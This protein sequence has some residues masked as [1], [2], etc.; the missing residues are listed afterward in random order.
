MVYR[1]NQLKG[2][3][4]NRTETP[5]YNLKSLQLWLEFKFRSNLRLR[6]IN[7]PSVETYLLHALSWS[8][9]NTLQVLVS[10]RCAFGMPPETFQ[11]KQQQRICFNTV[12]VSY[13]NSVYQLGFYDG[14]VRSNLPF[15]KSAE[16][17]IL[18]A[19]GTV[20]F[21]RFI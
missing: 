15:L 18:L 2:V 16:T 6:R 11:H 8:C 14:E 21:K 5:K 9:Q 13:W 17:V 1:K 3:M 4:L 20:T 12:L 10:R 19:A 7:I